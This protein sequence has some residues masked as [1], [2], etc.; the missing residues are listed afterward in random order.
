MPRDI[1][2]ELR[3]NPRVQALCDAIAACAGDRE[4]L[5]RFMRDLLT[6]RELQ[7]MA[8]RWAAAQLLMEGRTQTATAREVSM[9][10][11]TVNDI[12]MW[13]HGTFATGGYWDVFRRTR[14]EATAP[15]VPV[16]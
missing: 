8:N 10:N 6:A 12:A 11:K 4:L 1:E 9:S 13:V 15:A 7:D 14:E 5:L 3:E 16:K 2:P